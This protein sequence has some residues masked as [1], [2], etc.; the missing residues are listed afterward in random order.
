MPIRKKWVDPIPRFGRVDT[1]EFIDLPEPKVYVYGGTGDRV[2]IGVHEHVEG[3]PPPAVRSV[4]G[5]PE[6]AELD[7]TFIKALIPDDQDENV[8]IEVDVE[9]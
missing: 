6:W 7:G 4:R 8:D 3:N 2:E 5:L 9:N 1:V